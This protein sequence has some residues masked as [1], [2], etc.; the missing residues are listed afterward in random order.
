MVVVVINNIPFENM[1]NLKLLGVTLN[2]L[3]GIWIGRCR[4]YV[5]TILADEHKMGSLKVSRD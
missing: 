4:G 5:V 1:S 2:D 3:E